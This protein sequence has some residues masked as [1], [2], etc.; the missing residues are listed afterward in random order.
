M[1]LKACEPAD[2]EATAV[3]TDRMVETDRVEL[4][5]LAQSGDNGLPP[6]RKLTS[7]RRRLRKMG[8]A[9]QVLPG[10]GYWFIDPDLGRRVAAHGARERAKAGAK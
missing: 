3:W 4:L 5:L 6:I 7:V 8:L 2:P 9:W 1:S 10:R